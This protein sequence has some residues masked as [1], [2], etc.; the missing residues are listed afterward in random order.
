MNF[1]PGMNILSLSYYTQ[2][3]SRAPTSGMGGVSMHVD[4][5]RKMPFMPL[6]GG[7]PLRTGGF[8]VAYPGFNKGGA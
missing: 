2:C 4:R 3:N 8:P 5:I 1:K 7:P 6:F